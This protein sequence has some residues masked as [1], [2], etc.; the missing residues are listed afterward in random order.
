MRES[1]EHGQ[2]HACD[3]D[4]Y[5]SS[6]EDPRRYGK[7]VTH[8]SSH[9]SKDQNGNNGYGEAYAR[10]SSRLA[11]I[12]LKRAGQ[13]YLI[14]EPPPYGCREAI[15]EQHDDDRGADGGDVLRSGGSPS[16]TSR[17]RSVLVL[18]DLG[19]IQTDDLSGLVLDGLDQLRR[20][21]HH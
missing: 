9:R 4:S 8:E 19:P 20:G 17:H 5:Q 15:Y 1:Q 13:V 6:D 10:I 18:G 7:P 2:E 16:Q 12:R 14:R 3:A 21:D 11:W